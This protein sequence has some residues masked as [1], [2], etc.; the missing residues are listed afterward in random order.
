MKRRNF[1]ELVLASGLW[2]ALT[3][4]SPY[5]QWDVYR[6]TRLVVLGN[7]GEENSVKLG[8]ALA[9]IYA[10]QLPDSRATFARARN[11]HDLVR[12]IAG[13]Q[14]DVALLGESDAY[15]VLTGAE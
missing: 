9:E 8:N 2:L 4:H 12:L 14:L 13:K 7:A 6:K 3:G 1:L 10:K 11:K 15:D 5:K